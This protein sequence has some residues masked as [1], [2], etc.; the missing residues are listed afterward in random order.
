MLIPIEGHFDL[1]STLYSGQAFRWRQV[2]GWD[3]GVLFDNVVKLRQA[4]GGVEM[5]CGP[6]PEESM[7]SLVRD[8]LGLGVDI[9]QVC[10]AISRDDRIDRSI[11]EY[12]GLHVLRQ[13]PWECL[14]AFIISSYSNIQRISKHVE[15]IADRFGR[16]VGYEGH[17]R[18]T[19]PRPATLREVG[20]ATLR[21]MGL[22]YR[23][24]YVAETSEIVASGEIDLYALR[25]A[26]YE[27]A[28]A[29]LLKLPGVGDKVANCVLLFSLD[30]LQAFPVDVWIHRVL[31]EWYF[32]PDTKISPK[33]MRLWA[34]EYFGEYA[35][36]ANQYMF[37][38][39]RLQGKQRNGGKGP[40][41]GRSS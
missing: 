7:A 28:L 22:G 30:K 31:G 17:Q 38:N 37:H 32:D 29:T 33:K 13:E 35:G 1:Y 2:D 6:D 36:Y 20:E 4:E 12:R 39:R 19:F 21:E 15:D 9:E 25:E 40:E 41:S 27:E 3:V 14:V 24:P 26:T 5:A 11:A 23:A 18:S 8:Y 10:G 34:Q 16:A